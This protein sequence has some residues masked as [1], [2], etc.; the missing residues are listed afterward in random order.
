LGLKAPVTASHGP[1]GLATTMLSAIGLA[2]IMQIKM[3]TGN[4]DHQTLS[5]N[6]HWYHQ[7]MSD[8]DWIPPS[9]VRQNHLLWTNAVS[10]LPSI[11]QYSSDFLP[12]G[13]ERQWQEQNHHQRVCSLLQKKQQ[14]MDC[15]LFV[16]LWLS[17]WQPWVLLSCWETGRL[18]TSLVYQYTFKYV[19]A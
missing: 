10:G 16:W 7:R 1:I 18:Q 3:L 15:Q 5:A 17:Q 2:T 9:F 11:L 14:P 4:W 6:H 19:V 13:K 8:E 12:L